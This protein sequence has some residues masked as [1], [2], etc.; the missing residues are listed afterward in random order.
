V[1]TLFVVCW[2][3]VAMDADKEKVIALIERPVRSEGYELA[4]VLLARYRNR[5]TLRV[6]V[7]SKAG[8]TIDGCARLS[9]LIG[10]MIDG[11]DLFTA[12]YTL[13]VSSPGLDRPLSTARDFEYRVGENVRIQFTDAA[14]E[15]ETAQKA[16]PS[17]GMRPGCLPWTS[18]R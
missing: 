11:T 12:G 18:R 4:D 13:E 14:R 6:F 17:S 10:D 16:E 15:Q 5:T 8:V 1:P 9:R 7:Y 2:M 3:F